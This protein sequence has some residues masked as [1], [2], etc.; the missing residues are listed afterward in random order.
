[1]PRLLATILSPGGYDRSAVIEKNASLGLEQ[2]AAS[3]VAFRPEGER[4]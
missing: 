4:R 2:A 3:G 1:M